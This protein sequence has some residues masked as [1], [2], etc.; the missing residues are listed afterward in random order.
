MNRRKFLSTGVS[1][2]TMF[3]LGRSAFAQAQPK[4]SRPLEKVTFRFNWFWVGGCAPV[5]GG[6]ER[7]FYRDVGIDLIV[8][9]GKGS[10]TT[11][12][13]AGAKNDMFV[14]ADTSALLVAAAQ[15]VQ[16]KAVM[17][18]AKSNLGIQ[19]IEDRT[20]IRSVHDLVGKIVSATPGDGNTQL[21][22]AVLAANNIKPSDVEM[23]FL[24]ANAAIAA[25]RSGRVDASFCGVSDQ[26]VTLRNAGFNVK[27]I[28]FAEMG[29]PTLG[30]GVFTHAD[31]IRDNP[32]LVRRVVAATQKSWQAALDNPDAAVQALIRYAETPVNQE[33]LR[34]G[35]EVFQGLSTRTNPIGFIEPAAMQR[36][37][38]LLKQHGGVKTDLPASAFYTNEFAGAG[39]PG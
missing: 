2:A 16:V 24:D 1:T 15:G 5:V 35:L 10:G 12:R 31:T 29:A 19:W 11:V 22:P 33:V 3:T 7:G 39:S 8:G 14:W 30:Q 38:D 21:W 37:L 9:Q 20:T 26:P 25:L 34:G 17:V 6:R 23:V 27:F 28:T 4:T 18:M 32:D 13:Q 36:S